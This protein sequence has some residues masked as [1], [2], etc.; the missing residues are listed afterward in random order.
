MRGHEGDVQSAA[1]SPDGTRIVTAS[2]DGTARIWDAITGAEIRVLRGHEY[3]AR[4]AAFSP[5]STRIVTASWDNTARI[6]DAVSGSEIRV[7]RGHEDCVESAAFSP[8]GTRIVTASWDKTARIWDV[9]FA[10]MS[11]QDL[12]AEVCTRRLRGMTK[13]TRDEMRLAGY[14]D[15]MPEIDVAEGLNLTNQHLSPR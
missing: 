8:D 4:S 5:E 13:M 7:L 6:W 10:T 1:F 14:P 11:A 2:R 12:I 9:R 3:A 15:T